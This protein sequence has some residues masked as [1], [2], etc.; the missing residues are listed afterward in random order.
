[1]IHPRVSVIVP[2]FNRAHLVAETI[3]SILSQT[4]KDFELIVVDNNSTDNTEQVIKSYT[5]DRIRYFKHPNNGII[6]VN[7]NYGIGKA[8]G[9]Y[10]A[11][12]DDDDLWMPNKLEKQIAELERD[13]GA[14]LVCSNE[15]AFDQNGNYGPMI[16]RELKDSDFTL[17]SLVWTNRISSSTV[18]VRRTVLDDVGV[19]DEDP[20]IAAGED[21]ELWLRIARKYRIAYIHLPLEKYRTH[22]NT[23]RKGPLNTPQRDK[24]IYRKLLDKGILD[25]DLYRRRTRKLQRQILLLKVLNRTGL[26]QCGLAGMQALRRLT[27]SDKEALH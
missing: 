23:Y 13:D 12:C 19:M 26:L 10:I 27:R 25:V 1:M 5:D 24:L 2:T 22:P 4:F 6:A 21:Y 7:R 9:E 17:E 11:F 15:I 14:G 16:R 8:K 18:L 3:D 20:A